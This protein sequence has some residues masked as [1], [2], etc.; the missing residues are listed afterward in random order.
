LNWMEGNDADAVA[1]ARAGDREAFRELVER[2]SHR[3]FQLAFRLTGNEEDA[4][5][6]VQDTF[7]RAYR[8]LSRFEE[9]AE[10]STWIHRIASN[11]AMDVARRRPLRA[12]RVEALDE[13]RP[14]P[15]QTG[16]SIPDP[17][18]QAVASETGRRVAAAL[19]RLSP[20]ER[21]AF[22]LRHFEGKPIAEIAQTLQV[23]VGAAKNCVFRAVSKLRRELAP[24]STEHP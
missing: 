20:M 24:L 15:G 17:E 21:T 13:S 2:H 18:R 22:V 3:V 5:D 16:D 10:F 6:V 4:E 19:T 9:R 11:C 23:R 1:R 14:M 7:L 8:G 12:D